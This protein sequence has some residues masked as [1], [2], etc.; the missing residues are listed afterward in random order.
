ML[1]L[2]A[3]R[4]GLSC[5][6]YCPD[7]RSP[8]FA[9]AASR[10][11]APYEDDAA[12]AAFA[13]AVDIVTF[14]F[15]NVPAAT[16]EFLAMRTTV[17]PGARSL[18]VS[19]DRLSEKQLMVD[20]GIPVP[21]F[22]PVNAVSDIYSALARTGRPAM[23]KTRRFGYDGK[24]QAAIRP[25]DDPAAAWRMIGEAPAIL[26]ALVP[27]S[28]EISV[29]LARGRDGEIRA[30]DICENRHRNGILDT[31]TLPAAITATLAGEAIGAANRIATALDHVGVMAVEM[32]V[33]G[34][35]N[36]A[37]FQ[38]NEIAPRVHNSGHW[39]EDAAMTSQFEQHIRAICGWPLGDARRFA[40]VVMTNLIGNDVAA[41]RQ[42]AAEP[43][44]RLHLYGK[45]EARPGRKM[46][47]V[48]R[49]GPGASA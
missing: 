1:A 43:G 6:V 10:T 45:D 37:T 22:A 40:D 11:V 27:F 32:F 39:T 7:P 8:A 30:W 49:L 12:L 3:A 41:W 24:G 48:N 42:I 28:R 20:L 36:T 33:L 38:V 31:T 26:E 2:A 44:S 15:E 21:A 18:S 29:V 46:G 25:G 17:L 23:L 16:I 47:H 19:Q 5:H 4:L 13:A 14:E 9:V 34:E 35:G